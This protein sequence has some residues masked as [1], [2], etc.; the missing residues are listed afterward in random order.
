ME[1]ENGFVSAPLLTVS[2][3]AAYL[4][5]GKRIIYQLIESGQITVVRGKGKRVF[6]EQKSLDPYRKGQVLT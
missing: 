6:I 4:G 1:K 3:A 5:V 2:E